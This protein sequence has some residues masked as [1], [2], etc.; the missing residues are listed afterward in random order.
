MS[1]LPLLD[2]GRQRL[3]DPEVARQRR[4]REGA[5]ATERE[6]MATVVDDLI[7][8]DDSDVHVMSVLH[9][10]DLQGTLVG[11]AALPSTRAG[12]ARRPV[13]AHRRGRGSGADRRRVADAL[14]AARDAYGEL[15][16]GVETPVSEDAVKQLKFAELLP[17]EL[18]VETLSARDKHPV[19]IMHGALV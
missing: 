12:P 9:G 15:L 16:E 13:R 8:S 19:G 14:G 5:V 2:A 18:A 6:R 1:D 17:P 7:A 4:R 3:G 10:E 11:E